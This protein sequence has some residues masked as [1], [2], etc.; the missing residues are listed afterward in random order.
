METR[1]N[2]KKRKP[3]FTNEHY[4]SDNGIQVNVWGP[5]LWYVLHTIS[6][7]YP[8]HPTEDDKK[9]YRDF[10]FSLQHVLPCGKCRKNL[11]KNLEKLPLTQKDLENRDSFS[12]YIYN[13]H[14]VVNTMLK[15]KTPITYEELRDQI[16]TFRARCKKKQ[17]TH[18][19]THKGC[20]E[21]SIGNI[22]SKCII[23]IV[24]KTKKCNTMD[25]SK[26]C[27][28]KKNHT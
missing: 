22:K 23:K 26:K 10:V 4:N 15:K 24:P 13:L 3:I 18:K 11:V 2:T 7:N 6:F 12:R 28:P 14:S 17:K 8:T 9:H 16:E 21:P 27:L 19:K 5:P 1:M 25:I 20:T